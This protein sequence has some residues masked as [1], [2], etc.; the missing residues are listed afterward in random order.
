VQA[1]GAGVQKP[2]M[3]PVSKLLEF[4]KVE[5]LARLATQ[6]GTR[7][8]ESKI[9]W[10]I[11]VPAIWDDEAKNFMRAAAKE[12]GMIDSMDSQRLVLALEPEGAA[13]ASMLDAPPATRAQ[14]TVGE[15]IMIIDCGGGTADITVSEVKSAEPLQLKEILPASGGPWGG[16]YVDMNFIMM[17][18]ELLGPDMARVDQGS[19]VELLENWEEV[20]VSSWPSRLRYGQRPNMHQ[21]SFHPKR[22]CAYAV[23]CPPVADVLGPCSANLTPPRR[24]MTARWILARW[25]SAWVG[26]SASLQVFK[27]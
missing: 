20:K 16:T 27:G 13:I 1:A 2:L 6:Q 25:R 4:V 11:T 7:V 5:A 14:F 12:A 18:A 9:G 23:I 24:T 17:V 22:L 19:R 21:R 26:P 10:V 3:L 15:R 8:D